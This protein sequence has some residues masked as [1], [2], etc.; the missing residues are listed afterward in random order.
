MGKYIKS[1]LSFFITYIVL[2]PIILTLRHK[3]IDVKDFCMQATIVFVTT[4]VC[5]FIFYKID[6][7]N[8]NIEK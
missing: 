3:N 4:A 8:G 5:N 1:T 2:T 7:H 6:K